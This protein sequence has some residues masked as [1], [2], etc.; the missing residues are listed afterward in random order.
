[1]PQIE[2]PTTKI[3]N[4]VVGGFGEKKQKTK[5]KRESFGEASQKDQVT[6]EEEQI[7]LASGFSAAAVYAR[8]E[9]AVS[10]DYS[11]KE[12]MN[13]VF[14]SSQLSFSCEGCA[15]KVLSV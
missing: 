4:Y 1:M 9:G 5:K 15:Q 10:T 8:G 12:R 11:R 3:Y 2:G 7:R 13:R 14:L 6:K